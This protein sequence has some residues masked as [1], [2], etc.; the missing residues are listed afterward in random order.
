[1]LS[2]EGITEEVWVVLDE[3]RCQDGLMLGWCLVTMNQGGVLM[4]LC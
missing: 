4:E 2:F 1:M 3:E